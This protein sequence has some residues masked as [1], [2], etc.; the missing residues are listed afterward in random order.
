VHDQIRSICSPGGKRRDER[1][2]DRLQI[3][4]F[5]DPND[6][7]S[8]TVKP[9]FV[10]RYVDSRLC[11]TVT[12]VVIEVAPVTSF[13]GTE[14]FANPQAAHTEYDTDSRVLKMLVSGLGTQG[15]RQ[16]VRERCEFI[17]TI[18]DY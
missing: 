12:N 13:L 18:P 17:E 15:G 7:F 8:Y 11:P 4:A 1:L 6:L 10:D 3:V 9:A 5:S 14:A 2:I 16:E